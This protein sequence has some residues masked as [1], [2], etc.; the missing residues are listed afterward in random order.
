M[1]RVQTPTLK[2]LVDRDTKISDFKKEKYHIIH[3]TADGM[4]AASNR[5]TAPGEAES[6]KTTCE[7]TQAVCASIRRER[8]TEQPPKLYDFIASQREAN[9]L[10]GFTAKQTLDYAQPLYEMRLPT[11]PRT[12]SRFLSD[13]MEQ[14][15][16]GIV[17]GIVPMLAFMEGAAFF[18]EIR[19]VLNSAKVSDHHAIISTAEFVKQGFAGLADSETKLLSL[20]CCKLLCAVA[21]VMSTRPSPLRSPVPGRSSSPRVKPSS[22]PAGKTSTAVSE[23]L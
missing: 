23:P 15:A 8:K 22:L 21:P 18:A 12:D 3:I 14:T 1:G 17:A 5:F 20:I 11:S 6:V 13:D 9:R 7:G 2:M 10:F 16:A 4:E 19:R